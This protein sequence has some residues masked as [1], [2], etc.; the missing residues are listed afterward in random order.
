MTQSIFG[1][2]FLFLLGGTSSSWLIPS[3]CGVSKYC[4]DEGGSVEE[5]VV[6]LKSLRMVKRRS[7]A[8]QQRHTFWFYSCLNRGSLALN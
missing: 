2:A 6:D 8:A 3:F 5:Q 4:G 7:T 1:C